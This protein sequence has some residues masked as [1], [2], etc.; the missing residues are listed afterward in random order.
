MFVNEICPIFDRKAL[1]ACSKKPER[2]R[3]QLIFRESLPRGGLSWLTPTNR[4]IETDDYPGSTLPISNVLESQ[5]DQVEPFVK[6]QE[7]QAFFDCSERVNAED[8]ISV[9]SDFD[10]E[11]QRPR[12]D[13]EDLKF[14]YHLMMGLE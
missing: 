5:F 2:K 3:N 13:I 4:Q 1:L 9:L 14:D 6:P 8:L 12:C 11:A 10:A 7:A